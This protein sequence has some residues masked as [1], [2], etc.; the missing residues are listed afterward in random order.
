MPPPQFLR[1]VLDG[2]SEA[3][4]IVL[5]SGAI[6]HMNEP[7]RQ[8][9]H[10]FDGGSD[11]DIGT[12]VSTYLSFSAPNN[13]REA[14]ALQLSWQNVKNPESFINNKR[15]VEGMAMPANGGRSP[16]SINLVRVADAADAPESTRSEQ[17]SASEANR[18]ENNAYYCLYIPDPTPLL[19]IASLEEEVTR[20]SAAKDAII[21]ASGQFLMVV[22][23]LGSIQ[24][25]SS[26][27]SQVFGYG[28][29]GMMIGQNVNPLVQE[30]SGNGNLVLQDHTQREVQGNHCD[31]SIIDL[32][33]GFATLSTGNTAIM[34]K[35]ITEMKE[36]Q[37]R[38]MEERS[39]ILDAVVS[40]MF[41]TNKTDD[42]LKAE[43]IMSAELKYQKNVNRGILDACEYL[44]PRELSST[45]C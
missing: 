18:P 19:R 42:L 16:V 41:C 1:S 14:V 21:R 28:E 10:V 6:W 39:Q 45:S 43:Q 3:S 40:P 13:N 17:S 25:V 8:M 26:G 24:S 9:F 4:F 29:D 35:S 33:V 30:R 36:R 22:D 23:D 44:L 37:R 38:E 15:N 7:A 12:P 5:S 34:V 27:I 11:I 32:E 20:L 2:A 31:G